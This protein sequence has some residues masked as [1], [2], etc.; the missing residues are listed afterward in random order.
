MCGSKNGA[1]TLIRSLELRSIFIHC[2]G[3]ALNLAI[4]DTI[5]GNKILWKTLGTT[6]EISKLLQY[7]L[8]HGAL[9]E[10]LK[11]ET[12]P[13]LPGFRTLCPT[14]WTKRET[15]PESSAKL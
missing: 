14:R 12:A 8:R 15:S 7:P 11:A 10:K 1:A 3:H 13:D 6:Y 2:Y 9:I 4:G 5:K